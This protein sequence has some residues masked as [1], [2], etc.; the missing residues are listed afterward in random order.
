MAGGCAKDGDG[1]RGDADMAFRTLKRHTYLMLS[2][3]LA[4]AAGGLAYVGYNRAVQSV[5]V[6]TASQNL[7]PDTA[8]TAGDFSTETVP[9][10]LARQLHWLTDKQMLV[11]RYLQ[12]GVTQGQPISTTDVAGQTDIPALL[13]Y[14]QAHEHQNGLVVA[15]TPSSVLADSVEPGQNIAV[16]Y[17]KQEPN[18]QS[19]EALV[20]PIRVLA[21]VP[22]KTPVF[23]LF[24]TYPEFQLVGESL[25][26]G[27][28]QMTLATSGVPMMDGST[29]TGEAEAS[30]TAKSSKGGKKG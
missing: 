8:L 16:F 9:V 20:G 14:Y 27:Q 4:F 28:A 11:G 22:G 26:N 5:R 18:N 12:V 3:G 24:L 17:T 19:T 21:E 1:K 30:S 29:N 10:A 6:V 23:I 25:Q 15:Y 2:V 7:A 13:A